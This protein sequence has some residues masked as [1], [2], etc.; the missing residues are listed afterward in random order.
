MYLSI[1]PSLCLPTYLLTY[2]SV[3]SVCIWRHNIY[4]YIYINTGRYSCVQLF[5]SYILYLMQDWNRWF[6]DFKICRQHSKGIQRSLTL[7]KSW[8][9][10]SAVQQRLCV[11]HFVSW[12]QR[13]TVPPQ[14]AS[15][16]DPTVMACKILA[17]HTLSKTCSLSLN[18][19]RLRD[20]TSCPSGSYGD[21]SDYVCAEQAIFSQ[22][23]VCPSTVLWPRNIPGPS[24]AADT[25]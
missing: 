6:M 13:V 23:Q 24:S 5:I 8:F 17:K 4:T 16:M 18:P 20:H 9:Y 25:F 11:V 3:I 12:P 19:F 1:S 14:A 2:L 7:R 15:R 22:P 21:P 10:L